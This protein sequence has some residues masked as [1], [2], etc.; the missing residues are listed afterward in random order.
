MLFLTLKTIPELKFES[1]RHLFLLLFKRQLFNAGFRAATVNT[2][3]AFFIGWQVISRA[4]SVL[5]PEVNFVDYYAQYFVVVIVREIGPFISGVILIF[6]SANSVT[7]ELAQLK[8]YKQFDV[9]SAQYMNPALLFLLPVFFAFPISL[10]LMFFYFNLICIL[11]S[12]LFITL[13]H[14]VPLGFE[15]FL[16]AILVNLSGFEIMISVAK[17]LF[18]GALIGILS[19]FYGA[20]IADRLTD[21]SRTLSSS[22]MVQLMSFL[23]LNITLSYMAYD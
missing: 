12:Y 2:L 20:N 7:A 13:F 23:M 1:R 21:I 16:Q 18:G 10:L 8:L 6:R 11:S 19:I 9:L 22:N 15:D 3:I 4:Y 5:P 14:G 17:A